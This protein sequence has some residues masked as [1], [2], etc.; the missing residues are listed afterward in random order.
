MQRPSVMCVALLSALIPL[1]AQAPASL[2]SRLHA[3]MRDF[4]AEGFS[5]VVLVE[6][7]GAV[8]FLEA[9]PPQA[10]P[11]RLESSSV[12]NRPGRNRPQMIVVRSL[13]VRIAARTD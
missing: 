2:T 11:G 8:E 3:V 9:W 5:G 4:A 10:F 1:M 12:R 7:H 6:R 13:V